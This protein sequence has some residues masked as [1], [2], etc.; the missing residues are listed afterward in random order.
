PDGG[1]FEAGS[2]GLVLHVEADTSGGDA[3]LEFRVLD[4]QIVIAPGGGDGFLAKILPSDDVAVG[5]EFT[6]GWSAKRGLYFRGSGGIETT[7]PV[8]L[9]FGPLRVESVYLRL[10]VRDD[11]RLGVTVAASPSVD[12]DVLTATVN[13]M[14]IELATNLGP[15]PELDVLFNPP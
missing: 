6:L 3:S 5:F 2:I 8:H 7:I 10:R 1:R 14:G 11:G 15:R 12:L 4:G 9:N 13:R